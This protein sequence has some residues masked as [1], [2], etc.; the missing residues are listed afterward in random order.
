[1][2][3]EPICFDFLVVFEKAAEINSIMG[4][5]KH[6]RTDKKFELKDSWYSEWLI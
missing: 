4:E 6:L 2:L 1:M 3:H 5:T